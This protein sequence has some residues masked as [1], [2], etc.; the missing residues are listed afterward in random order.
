[1][2]G[3]PSRD[4]LAREHPEWRVWLDPLDDALRAAADPSWAASVP[5]PRWAG[6]APG[7]HGSIVR[8]NG[9]ALARLVRGLCERTA[10]SAAACG[11]RRPPD[12]RGGVTLG[13]AARGLSADA[14]PVLQ[15][16]LAADEASLETLGRAHGGDPPSLVALA[17]LIALPL[18]LACATAWQSSMPERWPHGYC[19]VCG[20]WPAVAEARGLEGERRLRCGR[21]GSDWWGDWLRCPYCDNR[22][23]ETLGALAPSEDAQARRAE[24]CHRCGGYLKTITSLTAAPPRDV[25]IVDLGSIDLDLAALERGYRRPPGLGHPLD[26]RIEATPTRRRCGWP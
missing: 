15:A 17:P 25:S 16:A 14:A 3:S 23:H 8:V 21:C 9:R 1:V 24:T 11:A 18:L 4:T 7:L 19:P 12:G 22:D 2:I 6:G 13:R 5:A 26:V 10:E 20:A